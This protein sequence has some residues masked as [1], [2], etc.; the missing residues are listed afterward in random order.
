MADENETYTSS[1]YDEGVGLPAPEGVFG[2]EIHRSSTVAEQTNEAQLLLDL[3]K[4]QDPIEYSKL[5]KTAAAMPVLIK[6]PGEG[7]VKMLLGLAPYEQ[8]P[9]L[10]IQ[11]QINGKFLA[12]REDIDDVT[13]APSVIVLNSTVL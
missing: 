10:P 12:L 1:Y 11:T 7:R 5:T 4:T 3:I 6:V 13:D 9:F 8:D 2:T